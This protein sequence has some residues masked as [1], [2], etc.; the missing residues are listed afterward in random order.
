MKQYDVIIIG[1]GLGSLVCGAIL[2]KHG[3]SVCLYEKNRQIGGCMQTYA[4]D[5]A[6][7]DSGVHYIGS[8]DEG[9]VLN[10]IFSY[11]GIMD[12]LHL[13][14]MDVDGFDYIHFNKEKKHYQLAQ[15]Y[16][17]FIEQLLI[18][19][20]QERDAL[21]AYCDAVKD[22][23]SRFPL[24]NLRTGDASEKEKVLGIDAAGFIRSITDNQ[25]L[26]QV[27]AGN[28]LLYAGVE[29]KTPFYVHALVQ[30]SY[31]ESSWKC[32]DGGSQIARALQK[33]I[34][35]YG[36]DIVRNTEVKKIVGKD[37]V[38]DHIT[39]ADGREISGKYFIS[40]L[41]PARTIAMTEHDSFRGAYRSRITSLENSPGTF[42]INAVLKPGTFPYLNYNYYHHATDSA[43]NGIHYTADNWPQTY[44]LFVSAGEGKLQYADNLSVMTYMRYEEVADWQHTFSTD[45][46]PDTRGADYQAFKKERAEKLL[47]VVEEQFPGLRD[48]IHTYYVATPLTYRDYLAMPEGSMYG[49]AKD[50]NDPLKTFI[51]P[52]T[53]LSNLYLTGQNMNLHGILGV[54][55]SSI[56]TCAELV[57]MEQLVNEI[58]ETN[59]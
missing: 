23:C 59:K 54:T 55:M 52:A 45:T 32:M 12:S 21:H 17:R 50:A 38:V 31:I 1:S 18:D 11:L 7:I 14:R 33:V 3:Y 34:K 10:K 43:W 37:G 40:G 35:Q 27:L 16:D 41:H 44:G 20:P 15:G 9:Q 36:G 30:N 46:Y 4:R 29:N 2:G 22:V 13:Q 56:V 19:F 6:I 42:M 58:I 57:G 39:L 49:V 24:F 5:K 47:N 26:Q 25:R 28:N 53:R 8:L 51:S 48:C